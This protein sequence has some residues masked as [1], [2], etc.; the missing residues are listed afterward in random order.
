MNALRQ[1][2][3]LLTPHERRLALGVMIMALAGAFAEA[4]G[5]GAVFPLLN[6]LA[7]PQAMLAD[8]RVRAVMDWTGAGSYEQF[9]LL[10]T[11]ALMLLFVVKN[12]YLGV[13]YYAQARFVSMAESRIGTDLLAAYLYAPYARRVEQNS[14][15]RIR[16][17]TAE[18]SRVTAG[19]LLPLVS[20]VSESLVVLSLIALLMVVQPRTAILAIVLMVAVALLVQSGFRRKL[21]AHRHVRVAASSAMFR[22]VS[23]GLGALKET[24]VL[25]REQH[26]VERFRASSLRY[27]RSTIVFTTM[28]LLPRL[29]IEAAAVAALAGCIVITIVTQQPLDSIVPMLTVFGLAAVRIMPSATRMLGAANTLRFHAPSL[30]QVADAVIAARSLPRGQGVVGGAAQPI[31]TFE[32]RNVSFT[33]P[34]T[35]ALTLSGLSLRLARGELVALTGRS[36]SGKTTLSDI[37]LGLVGPTSGELIVNGRSIRDLRRELGAFAGL[38]PQN[39]FILDDT[40]RHNVA[41]GVPEGEIDDNR[42]WKA[43]ELA[44]LAERV[45][46][47][48]HGLDMPSGDNGALLS[49]GE[50]QRL[51]IARALYDDPG[52]LIFDEAT[53]ALDATTEAEVVETIAVVAQ[54]KAV[55]AI[56]HRPALLRCATRVVRLENGRLEDTA[57]SGP[58]TAPTPATSGDRR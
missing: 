39:F 26:F 19:F 37:M 24:K 4:I 46:S 7:H 54:T 12:I 43:L 30:Q 29:I 41:F 40:I 5:I 55:L 45:A 11:A 3:L 8:P 58:A 53:S 2:G 14:A 27:A 6:L 9:V 35:D 15:D 34:G 13:L 33:Y 47:D 22:A 32:L 56:A 44:R 28:N 42:V 57:E 51:A 48:A 16:I 1:V 18:V 20:L 21:G 10:A 25:A 52:L 49:G 23:E 50:R 17:I 36:G 38:V 31:E